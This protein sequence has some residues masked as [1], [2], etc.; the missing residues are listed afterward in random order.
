[1][2]NSKDPDEM[3]H[4]S[5]SALLNRSSKKEV[6]YCLEIITCKPS[7]YMG[8]DAKPCLRW[9]A[10]NTGADKPAHPR[11]LISAFVILFLESII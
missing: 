11:S 8:L 9:F 6:T 1:M 10:N 3:S 7:I 2:S 4:T 5:R